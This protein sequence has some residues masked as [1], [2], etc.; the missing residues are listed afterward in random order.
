MITI[1]DL[2]I[3]KVW[4]NADLSKNRPILSNFGSICMED[5]IN[6]NRFIKE[7]I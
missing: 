3:V 1:N 5:I 7:L 6:P 4:I 2:G